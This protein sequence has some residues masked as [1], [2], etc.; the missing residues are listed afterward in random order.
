MVLALD[1]EY[2]LVEMPFVTALRLAPAQ[3]T[4]ISLHKLQRPLADRLVSDDHATPGHELLDAANTWRV[5]EVEPDHMSEDCA[6]AAEPT[7]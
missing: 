5:P 3:R 4:G 7:L 1:G 6:R 2:Y